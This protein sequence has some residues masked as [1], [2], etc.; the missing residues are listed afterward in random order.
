[1]VVLA[2]LLTGCVESTKH[3]DAAISK[4]N[5]VPRVYNVQEL[6]DHVGQLVEL[7]GSAADAK[8]GA[9]VIL[10][11]GTAV[12]I[13]GLSEWPRGFVRKHLF[14][15]GTVIKHVGLHDPEA[16]GI[17]DDYFTLRGSSWSDVGPTASS[18]RWSSGK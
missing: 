13:G 7:D 6:S 3:S 9:A 8:G 14:I 12:Y 5:E 2:M 4:V 15:R 10:G 16:G 11:E 17:Q 1:V 18:R